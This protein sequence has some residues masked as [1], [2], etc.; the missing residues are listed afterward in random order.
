M[1]LLSYLQWHYGDGLHAVA[2]NGRFRVVAFLHYFSVSELSR[3][4]FSPWH[5]ILESSGPHFDP[6]RIVTSAIMNIF[7]RLTGALMRFAV[8]VIGLVAGFCAAVFSLLAVALWL[9]APF[10]VPLLIV[11]G[12]IAIA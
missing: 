1:M 9:I 2:R 12:I 8:I 11:I 5:R 3:T 10:A 6:V 4:L 7:S